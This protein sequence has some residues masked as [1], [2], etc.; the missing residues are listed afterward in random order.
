MNKRSF[1]VCGG[2][3]SGAT[4]TCIMPLVRKRARGFGDQNLSTV[5]PWY[6]SGVATEAPEFT[7]SRIAFSMT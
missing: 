3:R 7:T 1:D 5:R 4:T 2:L 6:A